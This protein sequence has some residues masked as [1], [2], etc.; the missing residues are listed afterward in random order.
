MGL[1]DIFKKKPKEPAKP[2]SEDTKAKPAADVPPFPDG[3][4][5]PPKPAAEA[6]VTPA[7]PAAGEV[8]LDEEIRP[9]HPVP[10]E[11]RRSLYVSLGMGGIADY[12]DGKLDEAAIDA[13]SF[14]ELCFVYNTIGMLAS[15]FRFPEMPKAYKAFLRGKLL[16]RLAQMNTYIFVSPATK[17]PL[18]LTGRAFLLLTDREAAVKRGLPAFTE[19]HA[20]LCE[21]TPEDYA[22]RLAELRCAGCQGVRINFSDPIQLTDLLPA[23]L[24][25][26]SEGA[27]SEACAR[28]IIF[29]QSQ[30]DYRCR[31]EAEHR[32]RLREDELN[33][34]NRCAEAA[35]TALAHSELILPMKFENDEFHFKVPLVI[36][37]DGSK[38]V[39]LFTDQWALG[40]SL[41]KPANGGPTIFGNIPNLLREQYGRLAEQPD[42][43]GI[44][45]NPDRE[46]FTMSREMLEQ[47]F[48]H[49]GIN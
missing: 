9:I 3:A 24:S 7:K 36:H 48:A 2:A 33:V 10:D 45:V 42:V 8:A 18:L 38:Y 4:A 49:S 32:D 20:E 35:M 14:D 30:Y 26:D 23:S 43:S 37:P 1:F 19:D 41:G 44:V 29:R 28:M 25:S 46:N 27:C 5:N 17:L 6:P 12:A 39:A 13:L 16:A 11:K 40:R 22:D 21:I 34:L 47:F 31:A 15:A